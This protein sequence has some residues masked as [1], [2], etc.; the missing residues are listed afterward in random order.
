V[1]QLGKVPVDRIL[2]VEEYKGII[3]VLEPRSHSVK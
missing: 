2:T 1:Q 3:R